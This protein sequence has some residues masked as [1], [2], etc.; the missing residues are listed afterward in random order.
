MRPPENTHTHTSTK[1]T[2]KLVGR[3]LPFEKGVLRRWCGVITWGRGLA[4]PRAGSCGRRNVSLQTSAQVDAPPQNIQIRSKTT[5]EFC[6]SATKVL[7]G[8]NGWHN[9]LCQTGATTF[10]KLYHS[11]H[12]TN[13][14]SIGH[15]AFG[16][17]QAKKQT[18]A[19]LKGGPLLEENKPLNLKYA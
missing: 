14:S 12:L 19:S 11:K 4:L 6:R 2:K 3:L 15:V 13:G 8:G 9:P 17:N 5:C 10:Y 1:H 7:Q 18:A 16:L